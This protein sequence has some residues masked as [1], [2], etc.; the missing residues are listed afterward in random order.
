MLLCL[1]KFVALKIAQ[2]WQRILFLVKNAHC[3]TT[4]KL[5]FLDNFITKKNCLI[6]KSQ[7]SYFFKA[8]I[9]KFQQ[10]LEDIKV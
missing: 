1:K 6:K 7:K 2:I 5:Y 9:L 10:I 8:E 3:V 4:I